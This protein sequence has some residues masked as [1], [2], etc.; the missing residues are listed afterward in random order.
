LLEW[1]LA[2]VWANYKPFDEFINMDAT[3]QA[4]IV[5]AY[6]ASNQIDA[7]LAYVQAKKAEQA[8]KK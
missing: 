2:A 1:I 5:A 7:I 4:A 6:E 3:K 8:G